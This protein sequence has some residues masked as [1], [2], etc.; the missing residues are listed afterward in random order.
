VPTLT[1]NRKSIIPLIFIGG[2]LLLL[3]AGLAW[4]LLH[5]QATI[6][7]TATPAIVEQVV[8]VSI[9]D[10]KAAFDAQTAVFVDVRANSSYEIS[11][12]PGAVSIPLNDLPTRVGELD[13]AAWII[14]Y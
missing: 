10:A 1:E 14:P 4:V 11:H 12:I 7:V 13:P 2:G 6:A 5:Q 8:R 9:D 3:L